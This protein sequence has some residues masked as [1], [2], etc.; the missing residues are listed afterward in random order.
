MGNAKSGPK[1]EKGSGAGDPAPAGEC[2]TPAFAGGINTAVPV[3]APT[4]IFGG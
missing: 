3:L 4:N 2:K 1:T